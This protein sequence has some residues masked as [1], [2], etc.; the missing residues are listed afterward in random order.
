[1]AVS[2]THLRFAL[3]IKENYEIKFLDKYLSGS[4]YP[5]S[6]YPSGIERELTH[7]SDI[8]KPE[9]LTD[10]F[11][12]GW[13]THYIC[14]KI[15][16]ILMN[17]KF[18]KERYPDDEQWHIV[19]SAIKVIQDMYDMQQ[20]DIQSALDHLNYAQA[21]NGE[22]LELLR[23]YNGNIQRVY[24]FKEKTELVDYH[25]FWDMMG[26][27]TD[28]ITND[29]SV[30]RHFLKDKKMVKKIQGMYNEMMKYYKKNFIN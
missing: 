5:D 24:R 13:Q 1:M 30:I 15:Q 17:K 23:N 6:R 29:D 19:A 4:V 11:K 18:H 14:D 3:D 21:S 22:D 28:T 10:D 20:F 27:D 12:K 2:A 9:F 8:L 7:F 16:N 26:L 25:K